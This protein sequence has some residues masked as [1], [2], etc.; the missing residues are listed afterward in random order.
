MAMVGLHDTLLLGQL[1][2][3]L[4]ISGYRQQATLLTTKLLV[5]ILIID[6]V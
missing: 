3:L 2:S 4:S 5:V 6:H 1:A